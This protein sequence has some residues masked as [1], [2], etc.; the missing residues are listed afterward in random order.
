VTAETGGSILDIHKAVERVLAAAQ[1]VQDKLDNL[2]L[3]YKVALSA[4]ETCHRRIEFLERSNGQL[5]RAVVPLV[6]LALPVD[7]FD[8][9]TRPLAEP[10]YGGRG[11]VLADRTR[12]LVALAPD[13]ESKE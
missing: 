4:L 5:R 3:E 12:A 9:P 7:S 1:L 11:I 13:P 2:H 8:D 10:L 6:D